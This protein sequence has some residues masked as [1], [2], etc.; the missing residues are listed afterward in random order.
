MG[1]SLSVCRHFLTLIILCSV[2]GQ[3]LSLSPSISSLF[4]YFFFL[5]SSRRH[6]H[7]HHHHHHHHH[8]FVVNSLSTLTLMYYNS[9]PFIRVSSNFRTLLFY[10]FLVRTSGVEI[11]F[12]CSVSLKPLCSVNSLNGDKDCYYFTITCLYSVRTLVSYIISI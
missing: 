3:I 2:G 12:S 11:F 5:V 4:C 9:I 8:R 6:R 1:S 10:I 7:H